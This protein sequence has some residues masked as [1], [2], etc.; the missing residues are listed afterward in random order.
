M[1]IRYTI[2]GIVEIDEENYVPYRE[3]M[4]PVESEEFRIFL[5]PVAYIDRLGDNQVLQIEVD[6]I[7]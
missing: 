7:D 3:G 4:H 2:S 6:R 1:K 5:D